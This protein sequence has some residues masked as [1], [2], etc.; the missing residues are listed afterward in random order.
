MVSPTRGPAHRWQSLHQTAAAAGCFQS[1]PSAAPGSSCELAGDSW[2]STLG[3]QT[4]SSSHWRRLYSPE[5]EEEGQG[6]DRVRSRSLDRGYLISDFTKTLTCINHI[7]VQGQKQAVFSA[8][9]SQKQE[10]QTA[11][12]CTDLKEKE[13]A[14]AAARGDADI[15]THGKV[16]HWHMHPHRHAPDG[17]RGRTLYLSTSHPRPINPTDTKT[18]IYFVM[19]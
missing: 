13:T 9:E 19:W 3:G 12:C 18:T 8:T 11:C 10:S 14:P 4:L 1:P 2:E 16:T 6:E 15:N 17:R 7:C 5:S